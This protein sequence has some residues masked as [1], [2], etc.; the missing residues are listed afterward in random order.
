MDHLLL[1]GGRALTRHLSM[2][3]APG[4]NSAGMAVSRLN[5]I[6]DAVA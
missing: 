4:N 5:G 1:E 6:D 2:A 3:D